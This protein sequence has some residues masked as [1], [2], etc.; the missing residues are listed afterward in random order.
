MAWLPR[1]RRKPR[2]Q[3]P[4]PR[5]HPRPLPASLFGAPVTIQT[6][7]EFNWSGSSGIIFS[8]GSSG[9]S[10]NLP[11][12]PW[13]AGATI[14]VQGQIVD[15]EGNGLAAAN[16]TALTLTLVDTLTGLIVNGC[17]KANI[18]NYGRGTVDVSG[19]L[20]IRLGP[21]DTSIA[22]AP[23]AA[24]LQR[25]MIVDWTW[26]DGIYTS[27]GRQQANLMLVALAEP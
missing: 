12:G 19:D 2:Y 18:L 9:A 4:T 14:T 6:T 21:N 5:R 22:D 11:G 17:Y 20:T 16:L 25:S 13:P 8:G 24:R 1:G 15:P 23:G 27:V 26:A 7:V 3:H 10:I